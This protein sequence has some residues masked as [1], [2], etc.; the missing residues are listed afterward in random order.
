MNTN[1]PNKSTT[2]PKYRTLG[3]DDILQEGDYEKW[4]SEPDSTW[5]RVSSNSWG[6]YTHD[7]RI[8]EFRRKIVED[9]TPEVKYYYLGEGD[10]VERGDE[11][12]LGTQS[13]WVTATDTVGTVIPVVYSKAY[14]R[15]ITPEY[16]Y[17]KAGDVVA[18]G[19]EFYVG[20]KSNEWL[21]AWS[22]G[23]VLPSTPRVQYR[24]K[25][26]PV[27]T[28]PKPEA[29]ASAEP[30]SQVFYLYLRA[31]ELIREGDEYSFNGR[32]IKTEKAGTAIPPEWL[33]YRRPVP[34]CD[35]IR[36]AFTKPTEVIA[37][38][39][40]TYTFK[41]NMRN[42]QEYQQPKP[43]YRSL[44]KDDVIIEGDEHFVNGQWV[45]LHRFYK[46]EP[47]EDFS[48]WEKREFRRQVYP[49]DWPQLS[50][51]GIKVC[52]DP[53]L[54]PGTILLGNLTTDSKE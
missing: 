52:S 50:I 40:G 28:T 15:P 49:L 14:R 25:I 36:K 48:N 5:Q 45:P 13:R 9:G 31:G 34:V 19:D 4:R 20:P 22:V 37:N 12:Y 53:S 33:Q 43:V 44:G 6:R 30:M 23:R 42:L 17:L 7:M 35:I 29:P 18:D 3:P 39:D 46:G 16:Y 2:E 27:E 47:V 51:F 21:K 8:W 24:R 38:D 26:K 1:E 11:L 10:T 54:K 41:F 32:W